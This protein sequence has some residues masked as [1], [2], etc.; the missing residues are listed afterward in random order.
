MPF[1]PKWARRQAPALAALLLEA[2]QQTAGAR[3]VLGL[4]QLLPALLDES[5]PLRA[6]EELL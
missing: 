1:G 6:A 4:G 2:G 5:L 3:L